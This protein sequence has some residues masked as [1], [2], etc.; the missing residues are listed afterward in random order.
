MQRPSSQILPSR[1]HNPLP[2][3]GTSNLPLRT[4]ERIHNRFHPNLEHFSKELPDRLLRLQ[5]RGVVRYT[6]TA[7]RRSATTGG[8]GGRWDGGVGRERREAVWHGLRGRGC[9][10]RVGEVEEHEAGGGWSYEGG[11][12]G[13]GELVDAF[14]IPDTM[15]SDPDTKS[16]SIEE[17]KG[18]I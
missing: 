3:H 15:V 7:R 13:G 2:E 9:V 16:V 4:R 18:Y 5:A 10:G 14:E 17:E 12:V 1:R 11:D 6:R 8:A